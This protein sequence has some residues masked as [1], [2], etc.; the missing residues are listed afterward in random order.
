MNHEDHEDHE[1]GMNWDQILIF[2]F[3]VFFVSFVVN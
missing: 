3:V 2:D 1:G